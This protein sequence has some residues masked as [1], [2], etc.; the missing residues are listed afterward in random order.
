MKYLYTI[1]KI[2]NIKNNKCYIGL[3]RNYE[4]R[5]MGHRYSVKYNKDT[6]LYNSI[7]KH[8]IDNFTFEKIAH[9]I[10]LKEAKRIEKYL[11]TV[12]NSFRS[13][14][15]MTIG[16]DTC[17]SGKDHPLYGTH[18][19]DVIAKLHAGRDRKIKELGHG[20]AKGRIWSEESKRKA[21]LAKLGKSPANKGQ[22]MSTDQLENM[23]KDIARK[24]GIVVIDNESEITYFFKSM[25]YAASHLNTSRRTIGN[26]LNG[27]SN[28]YKVYRLHDYFTKL[29]I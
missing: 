26:C 29:I 21:S 5:M 19:P 14:Y 18:R 28:K 13:G 16:G 10:D 9:C 15:N 27:K 4:R 22:K 12:Y 8:G 1:Y 6:K 25:K 17:F 3:T 2:T 20:P 24:F 7:R 11:I 23:N